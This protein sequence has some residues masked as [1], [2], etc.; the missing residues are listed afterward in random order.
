MTTLANRLATVAAP[1]MDGIDSHGVAPRFHS[2]SGRLPTGGSFRIIAGDGD[3]VSVEVT[4]TTADAAKIT[5]FVGGL[6]WTPRTE[7]LAPTPDPYETAARAA[8][9][10]RGGDCGGIVYHK[11]TWGT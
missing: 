1:L 6:Y 5:A 7:S 11:P 8:G 2:H 4:T 10:D 3:R 9:W